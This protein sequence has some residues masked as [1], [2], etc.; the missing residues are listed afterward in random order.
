VIEAN[1]QI[2]ETKQ[3]SSPMNGVDFVRLLLRKKK[4]ILLATSAITIAAVIVSF[5]LPESFKSTSVL[6]PET[7]KSKLAGLGGLA[8]LASMA[9]VGP[10]EASPVKLYPAIL[11]SETVLK[12]TIYKKYKTDAFKDS[13]NLIEFWEI[14]A[15]TP[16]LAYETALKYLR[17]N[18]DVSMDI[19]TNIITLTLETEEP[20]L[21]AEIINTVTAGL[22][23][24]MRTKRTTNATKQRQWIED[25]LGEVKQD[26][27]TSE[28]RM[29]DFREKNR[30][31]SNSPLLMLEE[32]RLLRDVQ[33]NTALF[34]ELKKQYE[35]SKIEEIKNTPIVNILDE[36]TPAAKKEKPKRS[37][38]V[39]ASFLFAIIG[40]SGYI[41]IKHNHRDSIVAFMSQL[42]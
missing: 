37:I 21:T 6:L 31:V 18:L 4:F 32:E 15:K 3:Y 27:T 11:K 7:D 41:Y 19:K 13:V 36:A 40:S 22:D 42:S 38:I 35:L 16:E 28:N 23:K 20:R 30:S 9:G 10:G 34:G 17:D 39:A 25:R 12:S 14:K 5:I 33:I 1:N 24:F 2:L 26:L 29:K 8:D